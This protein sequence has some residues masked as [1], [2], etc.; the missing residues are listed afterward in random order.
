MPQTQTTEN[1]Y[2]ICVV[3]PLNPTKRDEF[4]FQSPPKSVTDDNRLVWTNNH[5]LKR[6]ICK[7]CYCEFEKQLNNVIPKAITPQKHTIVIVNWFY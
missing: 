6:S 2:F 7:D 5:K 4:H 3:H 1:D